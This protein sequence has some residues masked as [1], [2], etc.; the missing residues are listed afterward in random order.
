MPASA[1]A[2]LQRRTLS[3]RGLE[4]E[5]LLRVT[6]R[7][8]AARSAPPETSPYGSASGAAALAAALVENRRLWCALA[9]DLASP[10][11]A[12]PPPVRASLISLAAFVERHSGRVLAGEAAPDILIAIN[13]NVIAGLGAAA[14]AA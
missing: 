1:Y 9:T 6:A 5:V 4:R 3:G 14:E 11:N 13:R 8:D 10:A 2:D 7:L 12:L